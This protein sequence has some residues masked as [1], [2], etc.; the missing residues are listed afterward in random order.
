MEP[1]DWEMLLDE[2]KRRELTLLLYDRLQQSEALSKLPQTVAERLRNVYLAA[3]A[4]NAVMLHHAGQILHTLRSAGIDVIV[5]KGL[6][7]VESVYRSIGLRTFVD[8]DIL[9]RKGDIPQ[10]LASMQAIGYKLSTYYHSKDSNT[11]IKHIPPMTKV[12]GPYLEVHW[13]ILEENE[14]F[15]INLDDIWQR[16]VATRSADVDVLAMCTEDLILH[17]CLHLTYQHKLRAGIKFLFDIAEVIILRANQID[18]QK[19]ISTAKEWKAER[20]VWLTLHLLDQITGVKAP[21]DVMTHLQPTNL[22][23]QLL[24]TVLIQLLATETDFGYLT[25]DMVAFANEPGTGGKL[26]RI[27]QRVFIPRRTMARLYNRN[28]NSPIIYLYYFVRFYGLYRIYASPAW[29]LLRGGKPKQTSFQLEQDSMS[30]RN[31]MT[32]N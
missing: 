30:L 21:E 19:L 2:A 25:P 14:P 13:G 10:A 28:P 11:D 23:K 6:Y 29:R 22:N 7:L 32:E 1:I 18:W 5:L 26:K 31:W 4:R 9:V 16:A 17:L 12:N 20:V 15:I 27:F 24:D 8:L 3:S